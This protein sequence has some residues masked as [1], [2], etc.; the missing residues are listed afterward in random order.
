VSNTV[1]GKA[2]LPTLD[3]AY[4]AAD[5]FYL[6]PLGATGQVL[7][8]FFY[9]PQP[10]LYLLT[11]TRVML[12]AA[13][14][15]IGAMKP[16]RRMLLTTAAASPLLGAP[17]K[18]ERENVYT[19]LGVKPVINGMGT[20]TILGGSLM[21]PEVVAAMEEAGKFFVHLPDL[22]RKAGERIAQLI[23]VPA[24]MVTCGAASAIT[25]ATAACM[26]R[27]DQRKMQQLPDVSGMPC[28]VIQQKA[29][30]SG[31]EH[32]IRLTGAKVVTVETR[33]EL[34]RAITE[35]TAMLFFLNK[36][37]PQGQIK[38]AEWV[39][40]ASKH[41]VP[42]FNDA[43]ADVPPKERLADYV[44]QG[45]DLVAFSGGKG[46]FGPQSA[47][48]L[49]GSADLVDAGYGALSPAGGIGRGMKVSKEELVGMVAAVERY[50]K[51][52]HEAERQL[53]ARRVAEM[54][55][56]LKGVDGLSLREETPLIANE[57]P[58]LAIDWDESSRLPKANDVMKQLREGDPPIYVLG[59]GSGKLMVSVWLMR[60]DEHRIVA[61]R[62]S[63]IFRS[64]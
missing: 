23:G 36:N 20:V 40:V 26:T 38:R 51:V 33:Q 12:V 45:F 59:R 17:A 28:E 49:L 35:K 8:R 3:F 29:H 42:A 30:R 44:K 9:S 48:L 7:G 25:V 63:E 31:Y 47:G 1:P 52:D 64:A 4:P 57:V 6:Y 37:D 15:T 18:G 56:I 34:E 61:R 60:G 50:L 22:Q 2:S 14:V 11:P 21:P 58:H 55:R 5:G 16:S 32:Q 24:A 39:E 41:N 54:M 62:L 27:G 13:G 10:T 43:A 46:L 19:R 53:L